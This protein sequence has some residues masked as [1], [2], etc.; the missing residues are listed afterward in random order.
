M[1]AENDDALAAGVA[2]GIGAHETQHRDSARHADDVQ[3]DKHFAK[4]AAEAALARCS[5]YRLAS[6]KLLLTRQ[7]WGMCREFDSLHQVHQV[8]RAMRGGA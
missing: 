6:G 3:E 5:L 7:A 2:Q 1:A 8:L 4:A